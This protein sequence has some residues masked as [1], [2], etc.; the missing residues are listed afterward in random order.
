MNLEMVVSTGMGAVLG[1]LVTM[2][3]SWLTT[4][5]KVRSQGVEIHALRQ[6]LTDCQ[7]SKAACPDNLI[8]RV[9]D[10]VSAQTKGLELQLADVQSRLGRIEEIMM[11][12]NG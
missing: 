6:T 10:V 1:G 2:A 5:S 11:E 8:N 3:L 4:G 12:R 7:R 9:K